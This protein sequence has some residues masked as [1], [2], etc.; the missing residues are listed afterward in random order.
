MTISP[1]LQAKQRNAIRVQRFEEKQ[2]LGNRWISFRRI[3]E[4]HDKRPRDFPSYAES[5][6]AILA[7]KFDIKGRSQ[8]L[9]LWVDNVVAE[10]KA[11]AIVA[12]PDF[13][14][15]VDDYRRA[16]H[17]AQPVLE[18][19]YLSR[20]WI[21]RAVCSQWFQTE[22]YPLPPWLQTDQPALPNGAA[23]ERKGKRGTKP[24]IDWKQEIYP[25]M[26]RLLREKGDFDEI[27]QVEG[28]R[29]QADMER[30]VSDYVSGQFDKSPV[31]S[32]VR[33]WVSKFMSELRAELSSVQS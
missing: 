5:A 18:A 28:W 29:S 19:E 24:L 6:A 14:F 1:W 15:T 7:G 26:Q 3:S 13:R 10:R 16:S 9:F 17:Q 33:S 2:F 27:D 20:F 23:I 4:W 30:A 22:G 32:T 11:E 12:R 21:P 25:F 31:E 8:I